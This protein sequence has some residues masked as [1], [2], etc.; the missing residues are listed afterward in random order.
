[1]L[2]RIINI[3][4]FV[5]LAILLIVLSVA[6]RHEV[7]LALNPFDPADQTLSVSGPLFAFLF[8]A[9]IV[10]MLI[11]GAVTYIEQGRHRR[12]SRIEAREA[13]KWQ[14]LAE[15][16]AAV[17]AQPSPAPAPRAAPASAAPVSATALP[18]S[19]SQPALPSSTH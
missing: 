8:L 7:R 10:G 4:V 1:M 2:R 18:P 3:V 6:N 9:V 14:T 15:K 5:P 16:R 13:I 11:G 12:Q 19:A 17:A